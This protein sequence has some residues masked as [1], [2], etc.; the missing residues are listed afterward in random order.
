MEQE[1]KT[2]RKGDKGGVPNPLSGDRSLT[3]LTDNAMWH[4]SGIDTEDNGENVYKPNPFLGPPIDECIKCLLAENYREET[5]PTD[6][7]MS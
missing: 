1:S 3:T 4:N 5:D 2:V 6:W 7:I